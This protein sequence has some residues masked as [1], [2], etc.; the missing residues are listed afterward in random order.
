M[1]KM[2]ILIAGIGG[3]GGYFGGML[4]HKYAENS[5]IE[6]CFLARGEHLNQ[7][8]KNGLK[9]MHLGKELVV[10]P[11][12]ASDNPNDIGTVDYVVLCTKSYDVEM[13]AKQISPCVGSETNILTLLNGVDSY[14]K[15]TQI[16]P[17][18]TVL[19]GCVYILSKIKSYG[20]I[21]NFGQKQNL[22][23][24]KD[25]SEIESLRPLE[26]IF[27]DAGI[28][29]KLSGSISE[30]TWAKFIFISAVGTSTSYYDDVLGEILTNSEK[31]KVVSQLIQEAKKVGEG[32]KI[33]I[34]VDIEESILGKLE[35][36]PYET[37]SSM[38]RDFRLGKQT[39]VKSL[40]E[41]IIRQGES[42]E[43]DTS[44]Y[45]RLYTDLTNRITD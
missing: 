43:I 3:V 18:N 10:H 32:M 39:E 14:G 2:R 8:Q 15:L 34:D 19:N 31:R 36:L 24:G 16:F 44:T 40:T 20:V 7:I 9:V 13:V 35:K 4:A 29:A 30:I 45:Q 5:E 33:M 41:Y 11:F 6:I 12:I 37:T 21:E 22:F 26:K 38:Q 27:T 28:E 25:N 17:Q 1:S 42:L 23:F